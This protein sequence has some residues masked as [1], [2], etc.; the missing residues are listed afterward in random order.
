M[1]LS[2]PPQST[3]IVTPLL[4]EERTHSERGRR[5]ETLTDIERGAEREGGGVR[6]MERERERERKDERSTE[7][8]LSLSSLLRVYRSVA[9]L[10]FQSFIS[11]SGPGPPI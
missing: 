5:R 7:Q 4:H 2:S 9:V 1:S 11:F 3:Q 8:G 10:N 6:K